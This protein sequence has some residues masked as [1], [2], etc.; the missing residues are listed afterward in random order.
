MKE[1]LEV[2]TLQ[3]STSTSGKDNALPFSNDSR[4]ASPCKKNITFGIQL[5]VLIR[6]PLKSRL[7]LIGEINA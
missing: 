3:R 6:D 1:F 2:Q 7:N 5:P 4:S